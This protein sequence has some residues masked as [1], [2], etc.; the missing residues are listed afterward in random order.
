M[1]GARRFQWS[2]GGVDADGGTTWPARHRTRG[3]TLPPNAGVGSIGATDRQAKGAA[4]PREGC[5]RAAAASGWG[6]ASM[7]DEDAN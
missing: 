7:I 3:F 5:E 4:A 2:E 1:P 6:P